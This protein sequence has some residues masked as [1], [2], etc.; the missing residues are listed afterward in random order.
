MKL[1]RFFFT[2]PTTKATH[3][4]DILAPNKREATK[5]WN[6]VKASFGKPTLLSAVRTDSPTIVWG[7]IVIPSNAI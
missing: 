6:A 3:W 7:D 5:K 4:Q 1:Y 2:L